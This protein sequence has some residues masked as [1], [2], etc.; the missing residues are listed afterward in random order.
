[1]S[2]DKLENNKLIAEFMGF[3][4]NQFGEVDN[5]NI[6]LQWMST[7]INCVYDIQHDDFPLLDRNDYWKFHSSWDWLMPVLEKIEENYYTEI[8]GTNTKN[9]NSYIM[10]IFDY[11]GKFIFD[12]HSHKS[13]LELVFITI[14]D[15]IKWHNKNKVNETN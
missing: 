5:S 10:N 14:V 9:D 15:F 12:P 8:L 11:N 6:Y 4:L 1:M 13:K 3:S 2:K 7:N